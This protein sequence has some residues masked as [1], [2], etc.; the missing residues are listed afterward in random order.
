MG[1]KLRYLQKQLPKDKN[2]TKFNAKINTK[3]QINRPDVMLRDHEMN[4]SDRYYIIC[5]RLDMEMGRI[6]SNNKKQQMVGDNPRIVTC[7]GTTKRW[8]DGLVQI[9]RTAWIK[10]A[11]RRDTRRLELDGRVWTECTQPRRNSYVSSVVCTK[12]ITPVLL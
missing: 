7:M 1:A 12:D 8:K 5:A 11:K 6:H 2:S 3:N 4:R 9:K 10:D